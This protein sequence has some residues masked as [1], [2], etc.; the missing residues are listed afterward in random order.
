MI[1]RTL[2]SDGAIKF[3]AIDP[4]KDA[5]ILSAWSNSPVFLQ[6]YF[7]GFFHPYMPGEISK[8]VKEMLKKANENRAQ[9]YFALREVEGNRLVGLVKLGYVVGANQSAWIA[10]DL[11]DAPVFQ[12]YGKPALN[13]ALDY[14]FLEL[15]LHKLGVQLPAC[16]TDEIALYEAAGF[17]RESQRRQAVFFEGHYYDEL[18]YGLLRSEWKMRQQE[19]AG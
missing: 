13:L 15:S 3:T 1:S 11:P 9:F 2:F 12:L 6:H 16:C 5:E 14:A 18:V 19:V 10:V 17:L 8:K 4:E 7:D